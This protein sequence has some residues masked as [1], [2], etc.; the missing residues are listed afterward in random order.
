MMDALTDDDGEP[1]YDYESIKQLAGDLGQVVNSLIALAPQHDPFYIR[2]HRQAA[3]EWF[4][5]LWRRHCEGRRKSDGSPSN[6]HVRAIHYVLVSLRNPPRI[7]GD[8]L[9]YA[10]TEGCYYALC[11]AC[12]DA[13]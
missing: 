10:N 7:V 1:I 12:R 8:Q 5:S 11:Q 3:A 2:P 9:T 13:R 4:A 6:M